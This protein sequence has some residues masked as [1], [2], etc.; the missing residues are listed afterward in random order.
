MMK[1]LQHRRHPPE[2]VIRSLREADKLLVE[3][4]GTATVVK[5]LEVSEQ[6]FHR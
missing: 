4:A 6:P 1:T 2:Q 3:G 5:H